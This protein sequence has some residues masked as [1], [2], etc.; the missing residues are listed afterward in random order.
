IFGIEGR[1]HRTH[2]Q[3]GAG[4]GA[5]PHPRQRHRAGLHRDGTEWRVLGYGARQAHDRARAHAPPR[6]AQGTRWPVAA[7][8]VRGGLLH[9]RERADRGRWSPPADRMTMASSSRPRTLD[10]DN[11]DPLQ[12]WLARAVEADRVEITRADLLSGGAVQ[13]NWRID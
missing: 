5:R 4:A 11:L 6:L 7:S 10:P 9:D 3:H 12:R 1:C 13:E 8:C 2:A